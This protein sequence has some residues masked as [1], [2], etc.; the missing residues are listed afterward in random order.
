MGVAPYEFASAAI[1]LVADSSV[2]PRAR[3]AGP[4]PTS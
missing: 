1:H 3:Y 2:R 4:P